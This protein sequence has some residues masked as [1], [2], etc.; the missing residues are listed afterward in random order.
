[1]CVA[2]WW[3]RSGRATHPRRWRAVPSSSRIPSWRRR[4]TSIATSTSK[5]AA[6]RRA[7]VASRWALASRVASSPTRTGRVVR[8]HR[9]LRAPSPHARLHLT[10]WNR[11]A[12]RI[13][14]RSSRP[15]LA[16]H[17]WSR[18]R[19][20][21]FR[22][23]RSSAR[24]PR[25]NAWFSGSRIQ[26]RSI[27]VASHGRLSVPRDL[28]RP[29]HFVCC[30]LRCSL[31]HHAKAAWPARR[32]WRRTVCSRQNRLPIRISHHASLRLILIEILAVH[33]CILRDPLLPRLSGYK[34]APHCTSEYAADHDEDGSHQDYP[35]AP[36]HV[37]YEKKNVDKEG[38][39]RDK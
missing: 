21:I 26:R 7:I 31:A 22:V 37:R 16:V 2:W 3:T 27:I 5:A 1:M 8:T 28:I 23:V 30:V 18:H 25:S 24:I 13:S 39:K 36:S 6:R 4:S 15:T 14:T 33:V 17:A 32:H 19:R 10:W 34:C 38:E 9:F 11:I 20:C 12:I 29:L 35:A